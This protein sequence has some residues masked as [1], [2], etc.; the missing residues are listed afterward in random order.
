[1][2]K[3]NGK[4]KGNTN[5]IPVIDNKISIIGDNILSINGNVNAY[6]ILPLANYSITS[7][8]GSLYAINKITN[9]LTNLC[10]Q[11]PE[12]TFTIQRFSK[13]IKPT[14]VISNLYETI[15]V[16]SPDYEMPE[17]FTENLSS[18][19]QDFCLLGVGISETK[20]NGVE[21]QSIVETFKQLF[22][23]AANKLLGTGGS[24]DERKILDVEKNIYSVIRT[25]CVRASKELVFY[26]YVSKLY[27]CYELSY[28]KVSF[29]ND[30]T[31]SSIMG[32]VAQTMEDKFGYFIMHNE[33]VDL[34][35]CDPQVTYGCILN[36]SQFPLNINSADFPMDYTNMQVNIKAVTKEKAAIT[37]KRTRSAD[38]YELDE[39]LKA[40]A[41]IEQLE[42][43]S[44]NI[45]IATNAIAEVE[46]GVQMC[47][48]GAKILVTGIT[49]EELRQNLT[50]VISN[51][52]DRGIL[53]QKSLTQSMDYIN[54]YVKLTDV[55]YPHFTALQFP[56]SFQLNSGALVGNSDSKFFVPTIGE[57]LQ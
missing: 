21:D 9:L 13:K 41:E 54:G 52:K 48:F 4:V 37:L 36:I 57:D 35:D 31:F 43:T 39:A 12:I 11:R 20:V 22:S 28:D 3:K 33:G 38:K 51:L 2:A 7:E 10:Q 17:E 46:A 6:Y 29:I 34:F 44:E 19:V 25:G 23:D 8:T 24:F 47:E 30:T 50:Y 49:L 42:A 32:T 1:M 55:K 27:P 18:N 56:L 15:K 14:D 16:Y 40:G 5:I 45:D 53:P 26:N